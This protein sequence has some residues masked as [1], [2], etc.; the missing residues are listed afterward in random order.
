MTQ[1]RSQATIGIRT[2]KKTIV[3]TN[4]DNQVE[5]R[6]ISPSKSKS[7]LQVRRSTDSDLNGPKANTIIQDGKM[8]ADENLLKT[9]DESAK[10]TDEAIKKIIKK[11]L[12]T[13]GKSASNNVTTSKMIST[14]QRR[15]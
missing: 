13:G 7:L 3:S 4:I 2:G 6:F 14:S 8:I 5:R 11:G 1:S 12:R 15:Q 10:N 9:L